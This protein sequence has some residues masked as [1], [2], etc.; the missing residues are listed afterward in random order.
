MQIRTYYNYTVCIADV[1]IGIKRGT[2]SSI[3]TVDVEASLCPNDLSQLSLKTPT[4]MPEP[5]IFSKLHP[6]Q[7]GP[8]GNPL[9]DT[10]ICVL[11]QVRILCM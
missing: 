6:E 4:K 5:V 3:T 7:F 11:K 8:K 2:T 1:I 10:Y 9:Y